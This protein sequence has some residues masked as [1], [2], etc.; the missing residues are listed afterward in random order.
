M[1]LFQTVIQTG[2]EKTEQMEHKSQDSMEYNMS[3]NKT[4]SERDFQGGYWTTEDRGVKRG[5]HECI[6]YLS[7]LGVCIDN[8][9]GLGAGVDGVSQFL[10]HTVV[11]LC[12][13]TNTKKGQ[14]RKIYMCAYKLQKTQSE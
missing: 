11:G 8:V 9:H 1:Q 3:G 13:L 6:L 5:Q 10:L 14:N 12:D 2:Q 4:R 7:A